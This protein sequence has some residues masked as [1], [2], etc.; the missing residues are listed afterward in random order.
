M[1]VQK[2]P[3]YRHRPASYSWT[4][5]RTATCTNMSAPTWSSHLQLGSYQSDRSC[6]IVQS[7]HQQLDSLLKGTVMMVLYSLS[8]VKSSSFIILPFLPRDSNQ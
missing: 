8:K 7:Q 3:L 2:W 5:T 4:H 1:S 6:T